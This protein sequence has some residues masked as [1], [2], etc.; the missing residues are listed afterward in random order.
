MFMYVGYKFSIKM[1]HQLRIQHNFITYL[2]VAFA[3]VFICSCMFHLK[4]KRN[5]VFHYSNQIYLKFMTKFLKKQVKCINNRKQIV[6][7]GHVRIRGDIRILNGTFFVWS[8]LYVW[9]LITEILSEWIIFAR[10]SLQ[11]RNVCKCMST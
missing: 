4:R 5:V 9:L 2:C 3:I 11:N 1:C 8:M 10:F 7:T 6:Q